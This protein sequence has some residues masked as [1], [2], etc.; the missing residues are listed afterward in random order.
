MTFMDATAKERKF[1]FDAFLWSLAV[2]HA[3]F[4]SSFVSSFFLSYHGPL[5]WWSAG[6]AT[7]L[8]VWS[9]RHWIKTMNLAAKMIFV[10]Q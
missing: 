8:V 5:R 9:F 7:V 10:A 4:Q 6:V 3:A 1:A 2:L